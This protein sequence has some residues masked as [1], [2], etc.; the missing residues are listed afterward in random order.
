M[1]VKIEVG[2]KYYFSYCSQVCSGKC[3]AL[4]DN[5]GLFR[6]GFGIVY[7]V[8]ERHSVLAEKPTLFSWFKT[9][10]SL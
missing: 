2:K 1:T 3:L 9:K 8:I 10:P 6:V 7:G 5:G 4:T